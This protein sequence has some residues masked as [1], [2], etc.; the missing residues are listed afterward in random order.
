MYDGSQKVF[1]V[2]DELHTYK[3]ARMNSHYSSLL[4]GSPMDE[5]KSNMKVFC[6]MEGV[7]LSLLNDRPVEVMYCSVAR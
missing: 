1:Q 7:G 6:S 5:S 3:Q 4:P 2:F